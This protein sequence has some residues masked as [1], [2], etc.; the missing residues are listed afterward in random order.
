[1]I[2]MKNVLPDFCFSWEAQALTKVMLVEA[3]A[4]H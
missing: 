1:M 2:T 4:E 3:R